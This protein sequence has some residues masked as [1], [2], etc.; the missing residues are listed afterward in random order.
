[1]RH[2][3][4]IVITKDTDVCSEELRAQDAIRK[5]GIDTD[6]YTLHGTQAETALRYVLSGPMV[7]CDIVG[8]AELDHL[9]QVLRAAEAGPLPSKAIAPLG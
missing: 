6:G 5:L 2:G 8:L 1:M 4:E 3:C 9:S 7:D